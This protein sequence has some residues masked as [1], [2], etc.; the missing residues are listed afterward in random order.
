MKFLFNIL[1]QGMLVYVTTSILKG[2]SV[3]GY[4]DAVIVAVFLALANTFIKPIITI[5]TIPITILT[6][7]LFLLVINGFIIII[8][9]ELLTGFYVQDFLT[10]ILFSII[11]SVFNFLFIKYFKL[12]K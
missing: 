7:G 4:T 10:A 6:L 12:K 9:D 3:G 5:L 8:T 2:A 11:L 1:L